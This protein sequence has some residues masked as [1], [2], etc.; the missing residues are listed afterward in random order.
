MAST[1][2]KNL[3]VELMGAG[4]QSGTWGDTT[5]SNLGTCLEQA[6]IGNATL[7]FL[8]DADATMPDIANGPSASTSRAVFQKITGTLTA[9]RIL[10]VP[11]AQK[12]YVFYNATAQ[13]VTLATENPV[14]TTSVTVTAGKV[15]A[16]Y[17]DGANGVFPLINSLVTGTTL[18]GATLADISSVQTF[19][20]K[21]LTAPVLTNPNSSTGTFSAPTVS[22]TVTSTAI[23]S[24]NK[25]YRNN[26]NAI[27]TVTTTLVIDCSLG[28]IVTATLGGNPT[29]SFTNAP[30]SGDA[31][32]LTLMLTQDGT[33][34]RTLTWPSSVYCEGG[35]RAT[36][37][38]PVATA[39]ALTLY[40]LFTRDGGTTWYA[41]RLNASAY[42]NT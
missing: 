38:K 20:N 10:K 21:T 16:V 15:V 19:T 41:T 36:N 4:D 2:S 8:T 30:A 17:V 9:T 5:N 18:N 27:G 26:V 31:T 33:G 24:G 22:G 12:N 13:S 34:S 32:A 11:T 14:T 1:Y 39:S 23:I 37:L 40:S 25:S 28:D 7:A 29:I 35:V 42:A 6:I 3:K